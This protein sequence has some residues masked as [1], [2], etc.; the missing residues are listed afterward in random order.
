MRLISLMKS[1]FTPLLLLMLLLV[2]TASWANTI[3]VGSI[4]LFQDTG[5]G[6]DSALVLNLSASD[7]NNVQITYDYSGNPGAAIMLNEGTI[8]AGFPL[9]VDLN[10]GLTELHLTANGG[11]V[12]ADYSGP[13]L[14]GDN[15]NPPHVA[16]ILQN[17]S[18]TPEPATLS[19]LCM[20]S[21][22]LTIR[23]RRRR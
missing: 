15:T 13:A 11:S 19:L 22:A 8:L 10:P 7:F 20:G 3:T 16:D 12:F 23:R 4:D 14:N 18:A 21:A 5:N 6:L 1:R 2:S 9:F 17:V